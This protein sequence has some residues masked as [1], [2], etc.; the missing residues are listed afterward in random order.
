MSSDS[1]IDDFTE[2]CFDDEKA[3]E[4][5]DLFIFVSQKFEEEYC[6]DKSPQVTL[7]RFFFLHRNSSKK[8][9]LVR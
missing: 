4:S 3:S 6:K 7:T 2:Q 9:M 8:A 5:D 1:D